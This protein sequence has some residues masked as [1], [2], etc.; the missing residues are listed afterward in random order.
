MNKGGET[1]ELRLG[2]E[3]W[4]RNIWAFSQPWASSRS[5]SQPPLFFMGYV[6]GLNSLWGHLGEWTVHWNESKAQ[7]CDPSSQ[8]QVKLDCMIPWAPFRSRHLG[9]VGEASLAP[10]FGTQED[11]YCE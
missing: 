4:E 3:G 5:I 11:S 7:W 6:L 1:A 2:Q 10:Q 8:G 9:G